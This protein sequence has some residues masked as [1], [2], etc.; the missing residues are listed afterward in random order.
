LRYYGSEKIGRL[1]VPLRLAPR[2]ID[3][4][5]EGDPSFAWRSVFHPRKLVKDRLRRPPEAAALRAVLDKLAGM[6]KNGL[7]AN[8]GSVT[9]VAA[10]TRAPPF[11]QPRTLFRTPRLLRLFL[12]P[13]HSSP[14]V[15]VD[16]SQR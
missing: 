14:R 15:R 10:V 16:A 4:P 9:M 2:Q 12:A 6:K 3:P 1:G 8:N 11:A 13:R 7:H 5:F